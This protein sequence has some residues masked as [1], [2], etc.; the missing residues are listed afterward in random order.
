MDYENDSP[1][2]ADEY[3]P[4]M[5]DFGQEWEDRPDVPPDAPTRPI[6]KEEL[7]PDAPTRPV[8][9][10]E[11]P[12]IERV[13]ASPPDGKPAR[14]RK[15]LRLPVLIALGALVLIAFAVAGVLV[16]NRIT[17]AVD[18]S[19][20]LPS[21]FG[22]EGPVEPGERAGTAIAG[23]DTAATADTSTPEGVLLEPT[24]APGGQAITPSS[25]PAATAD[26][27]EAP[28]ATPTSEPTP[29]EGPIA[30]PAAG[31]VTLQGGVEMIV[32]PGGTFEMG[33]GESGEAHQVTLDGF[34]ID[35]YEVT[36]AQWSACASVG[37]CPPPSPQTDVAG[38]PYYGEEDYEDYP[39][40]NVTWYSADAY[41]QWRGARLPT[42]AEWEMAARWDPATGEVSAYPWGDTWNPANLNFCDE[43][44]ALTTSN[45]TYDDGYAQT[46][47][48]GS[49][50]D[51][52]SA[53]GVL[54]MAGNVA[55][56]VADWYA[57]DYYADSPEENP[58][59]PMNGEERVVR[60][61]SWGVANADLFRSTL[62]SA[63]E[64]VAS[65]PGVG[66]RC[67]LDAEKRERPGGDN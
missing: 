51:G 58:T 12:P 29:T 18:L 45:P 14:K 19:A 67:A 59:G 11:L 5:P 42:E 54:D 46:A 39:V 65:G 3:F 37:A 25:E 64:P 55:E 63:F 27:T 40:I 44:C 33:G 35:R 28:A 56:W 36:N 23:S 41:C 24:T 21:I 6:G 66:L 22:D 62:R 32:V 1:H 50:P 52:A 20:A 53:L 48:V 17:G 16:I 49:F 8:G 47:P 38:E 43:G 61:G 30:V 9:E 31:D 4:L 57:P 34:L 2:D 60:G 10:E 7:P 26:V 15:G 13:T